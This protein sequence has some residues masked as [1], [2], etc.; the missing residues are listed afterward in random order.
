[1]LNSIREVLERADR[2][3]FLRGVLG[4]AVALSQVR[5][6]HLHIPLGPQSTRLKERFTV[7]DTATIHVETLGEGVRGGEREGEGGREGG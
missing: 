1:M 2:S 3:L 6:H 4:G 5:D 7:V